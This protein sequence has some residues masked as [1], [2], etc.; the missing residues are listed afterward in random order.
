VS[1]AQISIECA[2]GQP[3]SLRRIIGSH[4][5]AGVTPW[6][7]TDT[8]GVEVAIASTAGPRLIGIEPVGKRGIGGEARI[9]SIHGGPVAKSELQLIGRRVLGLDR[10]LSRFH[11]SAAADPDLMWVVESGAGA[12]AR[13]ATVFEDVTRTILTTNCAWSSTVLMCEKLTSLCGRDV[14]GS[15]GLKTFPSPES[16][17]ELGEAALKQEVRVGYRAASLI[18]T[19]RRVADSEVDLEELGTSQRSDLPDE[20]V[21]RRLRSLPGVGPY[22]AAHIMLLIGRPSLPILDSWTRPKYA[23]ITG[24]K[25]VTDAQILKSVSRHHPDAGLALWLVLTKDWFD[26][27][28]DLDG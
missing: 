17:A 11:S 27:T 4:G 20:E 2:G 10:D 15:P 25:R 6:R 13:G 19:A 22:A 28:G 1:E 16:V 7:R 26:G 21:E 3:L 8:G 12:M 14:V 18:E 5:L 23:R 9:T 24:R